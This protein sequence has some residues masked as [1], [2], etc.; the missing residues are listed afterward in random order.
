MPATAVLHACSR[1][2]TRLWPQVPSGAIDALHALNAAAA[3][4]LPCAA[5]RFSCGV[6][7]GGG[8]LV[9]LM[10]AI[11]SRAIVSGAIV[12]GA[13]VSR[14]IVSR[15]IVS[16]AIVSTA[17]VSRAIVGACSCCACAHMALLTYYGHGRCVTLFMRPTLTLTLALAL[18]LTLSRC[19]T[20]FMKLVSYAHVHRDLRLAE[21]EMAAGSISCDL[22]ASHLAD[23]AKPSSDLD[24]LAPPSS[25]VPPPRRR[26]SDAGVQDTDA[27]ARHYPESVSLRG[28]L[29]F[30]LAPTLCY[31]VS[32]V[33][34]YAT[35]LRRYPLPYSPPPFL[36]AL[37][38]EYFPRT[39][40]IRP[41]YLASLVGRPPQPATC[42]M[43]PATRNP[44]PAACSR[45]EWRRQP[46]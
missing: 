12:S 30:V 31:Q 14:A 35:S 33:R 44:Q 36:P 38:Q 24:N 16:R 45:I 22:D 29:Y 43:H 11:G 41:A 10:C 37:L 6:P 18:T 32:K 46:T 2:S 4:L 40:R 5:V 7:V 27:Y 9:L 28:L 42:S 26:D 13:I 17:I 3:L 8:V 34:M 19:V 1:S 20:L 25:G 21:R 23:L 39:S 15:A